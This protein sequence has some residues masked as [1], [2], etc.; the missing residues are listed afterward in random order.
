MENE[1]D[2]DNDLLSKIVQLIHLAGKKQNN[3]QGDIDRIDKKRKQ[4]RDEL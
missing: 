3:L 2:E 1:I 4:V